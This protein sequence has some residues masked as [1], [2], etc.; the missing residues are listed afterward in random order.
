MDEYRRA[1]QSLWDEYTRINS[2][3][4][5][6]DL[7]GF[8]A[9]RNVLNALEIGE[10]GEVRGK[11]LIHLQCH[12]GMDT[13]S[14]A[15]LGAQVTGIDFS[16]EAIHLARALSSELDLPAHFINCDLYDLP[17][18]LSEQ[19]DIV[20]TSYGALTW[21]SDIPRWAQIAARFVRPGGVFYMAEFHPAATVF[22]DHSDGWAVEYDY[23]DTRMLSF[24]VEGSYADR[25]AA[26]QARTS[27]EWNYSLG[28][29]VS[30]LIAAGLRLEFLHEFEHSVY[31][32]FKFL[33][34]GEDGLWRVPPGMPRVPLLFSLRAQKSDV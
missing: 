23:F 4:R 13:L 25:G 26:T 17:D 10:L 16:P 18:R 29:V 3:S 24:P 15:R 1:N 7:E 6:Y 12:F 22:S 9:G 28:T 27:Y 30:S 32:Q 20:F 34:Q 14:W 5:M 31:P 8:K 21:L 19:F 33:I 2:A 11:R